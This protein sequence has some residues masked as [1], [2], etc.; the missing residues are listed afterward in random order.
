MVVY[1][2]DASLPY[3][4]LARRA[5]PL[6]EPLQILCESAAV[7]DTVRSLLQYRCTLCDRVDS[8]RGA[9]LRHL[10]DAHPSL[11]LCPVCIEHRRVFFHEHKLYTRAAL[12]R[13]LRDGDADDSA[14]HGHPECQFCRKWY[15]TGDD[16]YRHLELDHFFCALCRAAGVFDVYYANYGS[17]V[18]VSASK[19]GTERVCVC[20]CLSDC[21]R[22]GHAAAARAH[23]IERKRE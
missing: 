21:E 18:S 9:A 22:L 23:A 15:Y 4:E 3:A 1:T 19:R 2:A 14:F 10:R 13:H 7:R 17:L 12:A 6:Y 16:L 20:V 5:L 11:V 8:E